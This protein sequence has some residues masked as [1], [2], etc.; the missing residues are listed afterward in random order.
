MACFLATVIPGIILIILFSAV[1]MWLLRN[2]KD[3]KLAD[4]DAERCL[5]QNTRETYEKAIPAMVVTVHHL[6]RDL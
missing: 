6:G 3:I 4:P 2:N 5:Y 1:N